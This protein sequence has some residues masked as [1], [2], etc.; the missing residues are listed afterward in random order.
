MKS[1]SI[2][3]LLFLIGTTLFAAHLPYAKSLP[4]ALPGKAV[5][6]LADPVFS[7]AQMEK[8]APKL[9]WKTISPMEQQTVLTKAAAGLD[10]DG[11]T[12]IRQIKAEPDRIIIRFT[13]KNTTQH[14]R[15]VCFGIRSNYR[16]G[17]HGIDVNYIPTENNVLDMDYQNALWNYYT[18]P[19]EWHYNLVEPWYAV[20][21]KNRTGV[22]F[23]ADHNV[24]VAAY[25]A[26]NMRIRGMMF[27]GG[28][29]P[30]GKTFSTEI[31]V[32]PLKNFSSIA[33][34]TEQFS[35]G[36]STGKNLKL[37]VLPYQDG[38]IKGNVVVKEVTG[39][40][41][42][43]TAIEFTGKKMQIATIPLRTAKPT[44]QTVNFGTLNGMTFEQYRENGFRTQP[45]P[46][47]PPIFT[48]KRIIPPKKNDSASSNQVQIKQQKKALLLFGFYA[49][50]FRFDQIFKSWKL[51]TISATPQGIPEI[52]PATTIGEYSF[53][54]LGNVNYESIRPMVSRLEFYVRNGGNLIVC[55][56]P[57]A[58]GCGGYDGTL[59]EKL[60]PVI[61]KPFDLRPA[62][63]DRI[64]DKAVSFSLP[65]DKAP[66]LWWLHKVQCKPGSEV[67]LKA[68][69]DPLVVKGKYGKGTVLAFLGTP[70]GNPKAT[71]R[72]WWDS[73]Q[74]LEWMKQVLGGIAGKELK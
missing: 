72:P 66:Q 51:K 31:K 24:L 54:L 10:L 69:N 36:F 71:D 48:H 70:L 20:L 52:P 12:L 32:F 39:K 65:G 34:V 60:L 58:Y 40:E 21:N 30:P 68:G 49:N 57:F 64:Y 38:S 35:A 6:A 23:L 62:A 17:K 1:L 47:V 3:S 56:G 45:L 2:F 25:L 22:A 7:N 67:L 46:M 41:L 18:K 43:S 42:G 4:V 28:M 9:Q 14:L 19:G 74:Y 37:E 26:N 27:D 50:Y 44:T 61:P 59:L 29:L 73:A 16:I 55:G 8:G 15:Y 53:I 5:P 13:L 63:G 33:T 11:V